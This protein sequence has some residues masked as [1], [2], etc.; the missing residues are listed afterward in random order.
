MLH[1]RFA[2][3]LD[4]EPLASASA[5]NAASRA[6]R[7]RSTPDASAASMTTAAASS[8]SVSYTHLTLPTKRIV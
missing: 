4:P 2:V 8:Y 3:D 5:R 1:G 6:A 7:F